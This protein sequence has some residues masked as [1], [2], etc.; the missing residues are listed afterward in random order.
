MLTREAEGSLLTHAGPEIGVASTKC[1]IAQLANLLMFSIWLA[2]RRGTMSEGEA[3]E[4]VDATLSGDVEHVREELGDPNVQV[5]SIGL[6]GENRVWFASIEQGKSS[7]SRLG[8]G[9]VM[10][11]N[12]ATSILANSGNG[13]VHD[14]ALRDLD[15]VAELPGFASFF[16][17]WHPSYASPTI[18]LLGVNCPVRIGQA[19]VMPGDVVLGRK[20]VP[21]YLQED[22]RPD[23][24]AAALA[25]LLE[26]ENRKALRTVLL[27]HVVGEVNGKPGAWGHA[28][29]GMGAI[30]QA[31][32]RSAAARGVEIE[33]EAPVREV[34]VERGRA[35]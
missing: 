32:A 5:A 30:T 35:A 19:T 12:L 16:R 8:L 3:G 13:V 31:M 34:L 14:A 11:D 7:A 2:R 26:P 25:K 1:F 33:L 6:A 27:H 10:G 17:G 21:E 24:L 23:L 15:G 29:G 28:V 20:A 4:L 9:A 18:M 22:C